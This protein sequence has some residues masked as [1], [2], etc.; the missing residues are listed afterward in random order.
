HRWYDASALKWLTPDPIGERGGVHL[1]AFC[2][3]DPVNKVDPLGLEARYG[4][5][6]VLGI[7]WD[8][9]RGLYLSGVS[10]VGSMEQDIDK[11]TRFRGDLGYRLYTGGLGASKIPEK[12]GSLRYGRE[13]DTWFSGSVLWGD[14]TGDGRPVYT[15]NLYA[16]SAI[17]DPSRRSFTFGQTLNWHS[18]MGFTRVGHIQVAEPDWYFHYNND[19]NKT[20]SFAQFPFFKRVGTDYS[21]TAG[22]IVGWKHEDGTFWETGYACFTGIPDYDADPVIHD[23]KS[24]DGYYRQTEKN[25]S[26]NRSEW[27][28]RRLDKAGSLMMT[29]ST[30]E[31]LNLQNRVHDGAFPFVWKLGSPDSLRFIHDER[32]MSIS[33]DGYLQREV[34]WKKGLP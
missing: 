20:P 7:I 21:W 17:D 2:D 1:T 24:A 8:N 22:S 23:G 10:I 18:A 16:R 29:F 3:G 28:V 25:L 4:A 13:S 15:G 31:W 27:F 32:R 5:R 30:P 34:I 9:Q 26:F 6:I 12:Y 14:A 19:V 11:S 33:F